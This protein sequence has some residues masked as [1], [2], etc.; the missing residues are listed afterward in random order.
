MKDLEKENSR[1]KRLVEDAGAIVDGQSKLISPERIACAIDQK[2]LC[3]KLAADRGTSAVN[4]A[5]IYH[6]FLQ[7]PGE[8]CVL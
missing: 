3:Q 8:T 6:A 7:N 5:R 2:S 4:S 1:L